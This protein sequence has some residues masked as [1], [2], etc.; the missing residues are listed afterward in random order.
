MI[1]ISIVRVTAAYTGGAATTRGMPKTSGKASLITSAL[2]RWANST[3]SRCQM[4]PASIISAP[5]AWKGARVIS[6]PRRG[7]ARVSSMN[8]R[9][10]HAGQFQEDVAQVGPANPHAAPQVSRAVEHRQHLRRI[11]ATRQDDVDRIALDVR[12]LD[13]G[14]RAKALQ[15]DQRAHLKLDFLGSGDLGQQFGDLALANQ[16][17]VMQED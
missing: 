5:P 9:Q 13:G 12:R 11:G 3:S 6:A 14:Q 15:A 16:P 8:R 7:K 10:R 17:A 2:R 4:V 1:A